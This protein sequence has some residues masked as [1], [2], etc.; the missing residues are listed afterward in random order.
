MLSTWQNQVQDK[1]GH[2]KNHLSSTA[3]K[4]ILKQ[5]IQ[6]LTSHLNTTHR[7]LKSTKSKR[8]CIKVQAELEKL[9]QRLVASAVFLTL[10]ETCEGTTVG[11]YRQHIVDLSFSLYWRSTAKRDSGCIMVETCKAAPGC[12]QLLLKFSPSEQVN[13]LNPTE[14]FFE[15]FKCGTCFPST[16]YYWNRQLIS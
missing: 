15:T 9:G 11:L 6:I 2:C 14:T 4:D 1:P 7:F 10:P 3:C 5:G 12:L 8:F 13:H 16:L